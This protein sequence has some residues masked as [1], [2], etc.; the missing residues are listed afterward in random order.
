MKRI[1]HAIVMVEDIHSS[2]PRTEFSETDLDDA[3]QLI[4]KMQ[5][6][7]TPPILLETGVDSYTVLDGYF[8]YYAALRAE[9]IDPLK[10][11]TINAYVVESEEEKPAYEQQIQVFRQRQSVLP[12]APE[13]SPIPPPDVI[14]SPINT[15]E[16]SPIPQP[17]VKA[18]PI[19][20]SESVVSDERFVAVE[21]IIALEKTVGKLVEA[22]DNELHE[23]L[24]TLKHFIGEQLNNISVQLEQKVSTQI[25]LLSEQMKNLP[26]PEIPKFPEQ[27][28]RPKKPV[29][30][31]PPPAGA[32]QKFLD[33]VNTL[34]SSDLIR[35][36]ERM[37]VNKKVRDNLIN[38]RDKQPFH[39]IENMVERVSGLGKKTMNNILAQFT[40]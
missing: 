7:I 40:M 6:T 35:K 28:V 12:T 4:L 29:I 32:K 31:T 19:S 22:K 24:D 13:V 23:T 36:L 34:S 39:S 8:E 11:E 18:S 25:H 15:P 37:R 9:E 30:L 5:G 17:D 21:R 14:T 26:P 20:P 2:L 3:A 10:G 27:P 16:V 33:A 1:S 38:E